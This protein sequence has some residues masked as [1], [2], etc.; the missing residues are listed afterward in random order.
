MAIRVEHEL[1]HRRRGR[2]TAV[3]LILVVFIGLVF[4]LTVVKVLNLGDIGVGD[5]MAPPGSETIPDPDV[6][7]PS[8]TQEVTQ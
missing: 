7:A 4:A 1:H 6:A 3:G 8:T 2:N 5:R